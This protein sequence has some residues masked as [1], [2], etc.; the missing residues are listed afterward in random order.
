MSLAFYTINYKH[1]YF[2]YSEH[3]AKARHMGV[4]VEYLNSDFE[5]SDE[6]DEESYKAYLTEVYGLFSDEET[7]LQAS[8]QVEPPL[9][10]LDKFLLI[11]FPS[12]SPALFAINREV[13]DGLA[14]LNISHF[15]KYIPQVMH[16]FGNRIE[17]EDLPRP[18]SHQ[19]PAEWLER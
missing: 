12:E 19:I 2:V 6:D 5:I 13:H 3:T 9:E 1:K 4:Q 8:E 10:S 14:R 18:E 15:E 16:I 17:G 7:A 11:Y